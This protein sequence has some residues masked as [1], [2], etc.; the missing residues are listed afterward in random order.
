[1]VSLTLQIVYDLLNNFMLQFCCKIRKALSIMRYSF[2]YNFLTVAD[3]MYQ[4][5]G[6]QSGFDWWCDVGSTWMLVRGV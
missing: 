3:G 1:M 6:V 2:R 4:F 5:D